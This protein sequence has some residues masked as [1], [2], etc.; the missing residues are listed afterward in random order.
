MKILFFS[1]IHGIK[2]NLSKLKK[3]IDK[4]KFDKIIVLGDLYNKDFH[5]KKGM[6]DNEEVYNFLTKYKEKLII[7]KGNCDSN[8][9]IGNCK[10]YKDYTSICV[11]NICFY[12]THGNEYNYY[13]SSQFDQK[14]IL[15]YGHDHI[16]YIRKKDDMI[17]IC[18]GSISL[19]RND[20]GATYMIYENK[21][22]TI[23]N[24]DYEIIDEYEI[25]EDMK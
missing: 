11:D 20:F 10:V 13:N 22:F 4:E 18:V 24:I 25:M 19:P 15:I 12:L 8:I 14:G 23:Y 17:Y 6:F 21:K 3:I 1:D 2:K 7:T 16:P 5:N 9:E